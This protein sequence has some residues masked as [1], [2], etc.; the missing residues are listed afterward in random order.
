[1]DNG[2]PAEAQPLSAP[3]HSPV[4]ALLSASGCDLLG[5]SGMRTAATAP[6]AARALDT[7]ALV[8]LSCLPRCGVK[9]PQAQSALRELGVPVP[10]GVNTWTVLQGGGLVA[11]LG[12][13]EYL[14]ED[15]PAGSGLT[16]IEEALEAGAPGVYPVPRQDL[17]L[18]LVG[19]MVSSLW[20]QTCSLDPREFED[21]PQRAVM[22]MMIGVSVTVVRLDAGARPG[23]RIWCDG[24]FGPC[25][26]KTLLDIAKELGGG[27]AGICDLYPDAR[28]RVAA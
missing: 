3:R 7:V 10:A 1:M 24:S 8:D 20:D 17:A 23:F 22:T 26:F 11:R 21:E 14:L 16:A 4:C 19:P 25:V 2:R 5:L 12:R 27:V 13:S 28:G 9:G 15:G 18:A 6:D